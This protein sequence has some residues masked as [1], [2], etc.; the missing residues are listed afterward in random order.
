MTS[1]CIAIL[2][3][4][5]MGIGIA[6]HLARHGHQVLLIYPSVEQLAE[7]PAMARTI[8]AELAAAGRFAPER[9]AATLARLRTS[10]RLKDVAE[11][12]LLIETLPE[13]IDLKRA[14]YAELERIVDAEA[15]IASNTG[16][17]S[18]DR[19]AEGMRHPGRLLI[20]HFR[21]APH[22]IPLVEI[23][24][25]RLTRAEHLA[26][27]QTLLAGANLEVMVPDGAR[28]EVAGSCLP[29]DPAPRKN[30]PVPDRPAG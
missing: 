3:S 5:P 26:Y 17:L 29:P 13:R 14:L 28:A 30:R 9:A 10:V 27:V 8:L 1:P 23:V 7:V 18:P 2:G 25:G 20:A 12:R 22:R 24:P 16:G 11:A 6:T 21:S 15:V 4:G 19:L